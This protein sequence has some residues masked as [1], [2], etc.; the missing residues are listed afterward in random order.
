[1]Y[2]KEGDTLEFS[3]RLMAVRRGD[4][5]DGCYFLEKSVEC[6]VLCS[7][8]TW[9][10]KTSVRFEEIENPKTL[11]HYPVEDDGG[12]YSHDAAW[13]RDTTHGQIEYPVGAFV[14]VGGRRDGITVRTVEDAHP[15][16]PK[17]TCD[18]CAL[19]QV[20]PYYERTRGACGTVRCRATNRTDGAAVHF[21]YIGEGWVDAD[22]N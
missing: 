4:G 2:I 12:T 3:V 15:A 8:H 11:Y 6:P 10:D 1:V 20:S 16:R 19:R 13:E 22:R 18:D 7:C 9:R 21:E 17:S 14:C 5:C